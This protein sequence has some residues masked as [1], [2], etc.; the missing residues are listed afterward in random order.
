[1]GL[2]VLTALPGFLDWLLG[3]PSGTLAKR[4]GLIHMGL[5]VA[6]L[7]AFAVT[8][9]A[10][11]SNWNGPASTSAS[12]GVI[13]SAIG[14]GVTVAAGFF[15]WMLVQDH[16]VGVNLAREQRQVDEAQEGLRRVS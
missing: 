13:L 1:M 7:A 10:Y 16:Q 4:T 6:A 14:V 15:G 9:G 2:A 8:L 5:N 3:I 12:L 11:V